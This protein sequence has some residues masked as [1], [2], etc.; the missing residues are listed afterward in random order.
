MVRHRITDSLFLD[1]DDLVVEGVR[2]SGP[3]GQNV[4]KVSSAITLRFDLARL[5][6]IGTGM[7]E[8]VA[9]LAGRRLTDE[10]V[11]VI[12]AQGSRSQTVNREDAIA[13]L[14]ELLREASVAP[15]PRI[16]TKVGR[17]Q[18]L[19]RLESKRHRSA[20]KQRRQ[21]GGDDG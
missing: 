9:R 21:A 7:R 17:G 10:G 8:R 20:T 15:R 5:P 3:G 13:R 1:E 11:I 4:N 16:K 18:R 12:K 6:G 2:A 14:L 19:R